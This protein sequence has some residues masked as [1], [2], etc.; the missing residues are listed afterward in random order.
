MSFPH[1][2]HTDLDLIH[3]AIL[4]LSLTHPGSCGGGSCP[5]ASCT[6]SPAPLV[7]SPGPVSLH[8]VA[9]S[10]FAASLLQTATKKS[11][12]Y[13]YVCVLD[14]LCFVDGHRHMNCSWRSFQLSLKQAICLLHKYFNSL[15]VW[16]VHMCDIIP[17]SRFGHQFH[18]KT[19]CIC[20]IGCM[21]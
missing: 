20:S 13:W 18:W 15:Q 10:P 1:R 11:I 8:A 7:S 4:T 21:N 14:I 2:H 5:V 17:A 12:N 6:A 16:I 3:N 19:H 9:Q